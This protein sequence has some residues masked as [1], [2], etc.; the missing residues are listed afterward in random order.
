M[1]AFGVHI[2]EEKFRHLSERIAQWTGT[3][4]SFILALGMIV[5]WAVSGPVFGYSDTWQL[6]INTGTTIVTFL[7]VFLIQ[8]TQ[9]RDAVA[10]QLKLDELLRV[11]RGA[12][13]GMINVE[14]L[15]NEELEKLRRDLQEVGRKEGCD[16]ASIEA[17]VSSSS[18]RRQDDSLLTQETRSEHSVEIEI[19]KRGKGDESK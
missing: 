1:L 4:W 17:K 13:T 3:S 11:I 6:V 16:L 7:M 9:N 14:Q 19:E 8:N 15:T 2:M 10:V 5:L 12:R 18:K